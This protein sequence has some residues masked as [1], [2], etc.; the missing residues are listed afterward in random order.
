MVGERATGATATGGIPMN[1]SNDKTTAER[2]RTWW[3][4]P[5]RTG[6]QR[7]IAPWEYR[8]IRAFGAT[9][10]FGGSI[11]A[12]AGF[13]CFAYHTYGWAAFFLG[14]GALHVAAGYWFITIDR[15]AS[16]RA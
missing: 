8:H 14:L 1:A 11:A 4:S 9:H 15:S 5:P 6:M 12:A 10:I 13:I 7:L 3:L 16:D 2:L